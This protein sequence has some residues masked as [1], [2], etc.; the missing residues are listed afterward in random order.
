MKAG[1]FKHH[2]QY[3]RA[4]PKHVSVNNGLQVDGVA[5]RT[6]QFLSTSDVVQH[7]AGVFV[8]MLV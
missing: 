7:I 1:Y 4:P 5:I 8:V 6:E 2:V 3:S